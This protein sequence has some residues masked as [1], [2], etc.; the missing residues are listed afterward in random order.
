[1]H[2]G[3]I[4]AGMMGHG[5]AANLL[6]HGHQVSVIAH[7][8]RGPV[9]DLVAKGAREVHSLT[10]MA[11]AEVILLCVTTSKVV[12]ETLKQLTPHLRP[13]QIIL[14]AGTS[15]P[16]ATKRL[17]HALDAL[18]VAYA[19]IPLTGGPEQA[20]QGVLGVLCGA[21]PETFARI[22]PLLACFATTIRHFGP[23]GSGHTAKLISNYLVTGMVALVAEAFG[24]ARTAQIDWKD[25]YEVMLNGSGNSGVLRKMVEPALK[26]DFDGYRFALANA[27]KDI[28]Y[29]AELAEGLGCGTKL[30]ESVAEVF[31]HAVETGHGGR[32]VS[33]LL[34]PAIDDVS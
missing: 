27:A 11:E 18:G 28:G 1:M 7:R 4:G 34:D 2:V 21:T 15:A 6:K 10:E 25:L 5:M 16:A 8:N 26:G 23:P 22:E 29:Y 12:E 13:G 17:A 33:H 30:T 32:N 31:A 19:D 14:D 9:E 20:E 24:A 3:L